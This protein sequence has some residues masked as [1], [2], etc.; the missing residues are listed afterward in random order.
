MSKRSPF[1]VSFV[2]SLIIAS[3]LTAIY[4]YRPTERAQNTDFNTST[5]TTEINK[6]TNEGQTVRTLLQQNLQSSIDELE[7]EGKPHPKVTFESQIIAPQPPENENITQSQSSIATKVIAKTTIEYTGPQQAGKSRWD[8]IIVR[9]QDST[10]SGSDNGIVL[11]G[12][13]TQK[14]INKHPEIYGKGHYEYGK[15]PRTFVID[16]NMTTT[17]VQTPQKS[18]LSEN[19]GTSPSDFTRQT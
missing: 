2:L 9:K 8:D 19:V 15:E 13:L 5:N 11:E 17:F 12:N 10:F 14:L 3:A 6:Q 7:R 1:L 4:L 16:E 18:I